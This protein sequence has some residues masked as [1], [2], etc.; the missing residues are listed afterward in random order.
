M[1]LDPLGATYAVLDVDLADD[2]TTTL[3]YDGAATH[4]DTA[5]ADA[6]ARCRAD[7]GRTSV[8]C[9]ITPVSFFAGRAPARN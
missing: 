3:R 5:S 4:P 2:G 8:V 7:E 1:T 9:R 6:E